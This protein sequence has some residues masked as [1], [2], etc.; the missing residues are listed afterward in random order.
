MIEISLLYYIVAKKLY[1]I[2]D[3][4]TKT[5][6]FSFLSLCQFFCHIKCYNGSVNRIF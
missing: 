2:S 6:R 4:N 3:K 5:E 1:I